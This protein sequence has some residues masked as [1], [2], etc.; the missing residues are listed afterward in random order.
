MCAV[1]I[2]GTLGT[3]IPANNVFASELKTLANID[4]TKVI[5]VVIDDKVVQLQDQNPVMDTKAGRVLVPFRKI[6]EELGFEVTWFSSTQEVMFETANRKATLK[7]GSKDA[8][9][10]GKAVKID[11]APIVISGRTMVPIRFLAEAF[12]CDVDWNSTLKT[13]YIDTTAGEGLTIDEQAMFD[14]LVLPGVSDG[15]DTNVTK[16]PYVPVVI[17]GGEAGYW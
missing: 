15:L 9:V 3:V 5:V 13:V 14:S 17:D 10:D 7:I 11:V 2:V 16:E 1:L 4:T 8:I 12:S 6:A